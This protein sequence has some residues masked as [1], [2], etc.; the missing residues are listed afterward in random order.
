MKRT[1]EEWRQEWL[2]TWQEGVSRD[3]RL[4]ILRWEI[5]MMILEI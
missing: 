2:S 3:W 4:F 1:N 5:F